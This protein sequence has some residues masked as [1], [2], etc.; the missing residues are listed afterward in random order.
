VVFG[1]LVVAVLLARTG[2]SHFNREE[3]L[4]RE[5]DI[6]NFRWMWLVVKGQFVGKAT[7]IRSWY[8]KE[9]RGTLRKMRFPFVVMT[10]I[11]IGAIFFGNYLATVFVIPQ[12]LIDLSNVDILID[13]LEI[14]MEELTIGEVVS[15]ILFIW[16]HNIRAIAVSTFIGVFTFG[17]LGIIGLNVAI[18]LL[19][20]FM[21][22]AVAAGIP[23]WEYWFGFVVPHGIFEVPV[24]LLSGA[25]VLKIGAGLAAPNKG[26][27]IGE[28]LLRSLAD[29]A[30]ILVGILL[31]LLLAASIMEVLVTPEAVIW[32]LSN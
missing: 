28:G 8:S 30:K 19:G 4:G 14:V 23:A 18:V 15:A 5:L 24:I 21:V 2:I 7:S 9:I 29:W 1:L 25:L 10:V 11:F 17:I 31:P 13:Q 12:E 20:Y 22:P 26:E 6:L 3:L 27:S 32:V 16:L